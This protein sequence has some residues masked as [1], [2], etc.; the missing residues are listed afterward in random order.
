[1]Q[2]ETL[3]QKTIY[4]LK[5]ISLGLILGLG[6]QFAQAWKS[7]DATPPPEGNI[8][9]PIT[10]GSDGQQK[11][12]NLAV[13]VGWD[14]NGDSVIDSWGTQGLIVMHGDVGIGT[15]SP[16]AKLHLMGATDLGI[17]VQSNDNANGT[18]RLM[19]GSQSGQHCGDFVFA[20]SDT[21]TTKPTLGLYS[22]CSGPGNGD[23]KLQPGFAGGNVYVPEGNVGIGVRNPISTKGASGY[24]DVKDA[25]LRDV[26]KWASEV[27]G[28]GASSPKGTLCGVFA[29]SNDLG[30]WLGAGCQDALPGSCPSGYYIFSPGGGISYCMKS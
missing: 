22:S 16:T 25:Y 27:S 4:W 21:I 3:A 10:M 20:E 2:K 26:G 7:P 24:I 5:V 11:A 12:G 29:F 6:I 28:G 13:N 1:M 14:T 17:K 9:G 18:S 8:S 19:L 23:I 30:V 15:G